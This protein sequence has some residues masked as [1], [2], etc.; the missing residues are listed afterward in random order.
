MVCQDETLYSPAAETIP[1]IQK[2]N[3][4]L[5]ERS[6]SLV[7][8]F[9]NILLRVQQQADLRPASKPLHSLADTVF[10]I[11]VHGK[12]EKLLRTPKIYYE[13][14]QLICSKMIEFVESW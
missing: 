10:E 14:G 4:R 5:W 2:D 12:Y 1:N 9:A 11:Y 6:S 13:E 8:E 3:E 7:P